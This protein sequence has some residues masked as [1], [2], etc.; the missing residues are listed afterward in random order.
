MDPHLSGA[1]KTEIQ[2][3]Q[4]QV[5]NGKYDGYHIAAEAPLPNNPKH[6]IIIVEKHPKTESVPTETTKE[7]REE[8]DD[9]YVQI[10]SPTSREKISIMAVIDRCRA[11]QESDEY[12]QRE[13]AK[14]KT[15]SARPQELDKTSASPTDQGDKSQNTRS[16]SGQKTEAGQQS[17]VKN[18]REKFQSLS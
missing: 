11:Y 4:D 2:K 7:S 6:K 10:R 15:E 9:N 18:L 1:Q 8:E 17:I 13:E 16:N 5:S 14:A 12:K 3:L